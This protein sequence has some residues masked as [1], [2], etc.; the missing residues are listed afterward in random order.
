MRYRP[1]ISPQSQAFQLRP[2]SCATNADGRL[3]EG[4]AESEAAEW[5][6][7]NALM[8]DNR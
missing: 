7:A 3:P 1:M 5:Q 2:R 4:I 6:D 8:H